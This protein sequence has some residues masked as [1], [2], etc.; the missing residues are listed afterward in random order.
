M[1]IIIPDNLPAVEVL[2]SKH[3]C[4]EER[5]AVHQDIRPLRIAILNL[6][7]QKIVTETQLLRVLAN[8]Y[9]WNL[10]CCALKPRIQNTPES[11]ANL[12]YHFCRVKQD[13]TA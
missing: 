12:L 13:S 4:Y 10:F 11:P 5:R 7:P 1:P 6:M 8:T 3:I 2:Q 9:K